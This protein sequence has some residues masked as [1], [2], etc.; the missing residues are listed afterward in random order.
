MYPEIF[1]IGDFAISSFGLMLVVAF[2]ASYFQLAHGLRRLGAG[3][4][5]EPDVGARPPPAREEE[6]HQP[7]AGVA[8]LHPS[9]AG[10]AREARDRGGAEG[11][12]V[13][14]EQ[15]IDDGHR[16]PVVG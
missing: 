5:E 6:G 15:G 16:G 12:H 1:R 3:D 4:E 14:E 7:E 11:R 10:D 13:E 2:V 8:I 9:R